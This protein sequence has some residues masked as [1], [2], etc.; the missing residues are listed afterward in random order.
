MKGK[1][2]PVAW[3]LAVAAVLTGCEGRQ[4][5]ITVAGSTSVQPFME[6]LAEEYM[7]RSPRVQINVQ[8]GGSSAGIKAVTDGT[9]DL[10]MAS[11]RLTG[12]ELSQGIVST[13]IARDGIAVITH[14]DNPVDSL[15]L[16]Q[17][18]NIFSG[19]VTAWNAFGGSG[20]ITVVVR[21]EGSGTRGAFD[22]LAMGEQA[23]TRDAV[24]LGSTGAVRAAVAGDPGAIGY[25]SL[26]QADQSVKVISIDGVE[27]SQENV[28]NGRY[29][30]ARP[31]IIMTG[32]APT[33]SVK[34]FIDFIT[35]PDG[36]Q[37]LLNEGMVV[38]Q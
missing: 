11:R 35:S 6:L 26:A 18:R 2:F 5:S 8:G 20:R 29:V 4:N 33:D 21:E 25:I 3:L 9:A 37:I 16:D 13:V 31:F 10:G 22:E 36:R 28:G 30:I 24:V 19:R 17:L 7:S 23:V 32:G 27:P 1:W 14:P 15:S 38:A 34:R 12:D